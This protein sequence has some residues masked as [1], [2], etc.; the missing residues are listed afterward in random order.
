[1]GSVAPTPGRG[2][3]VYMN[4]TGTV[5]I[6]GVEVSSPQTLNLLAGWNMIANPFDV[7]IPWTKVKLNGAAMTPTTYVYS[8]NGIVYQPVIFATG[9][10]A[11]GEGYWIYMASA[12]TI[13]FSR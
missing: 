12:G 3:W 10:L 8:Y 7:A 11:I 5:T 6:T 9:S 4:A 13:E 2:F 1:M